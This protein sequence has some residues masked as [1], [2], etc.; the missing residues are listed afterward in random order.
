MLMVAVPDC[1]HD[2]VNHRL[3]FED[4]ND[5]T[6][7]INAIKGSWVLCKSRFCALH[8]TSDD[9]FYSHI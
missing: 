8:G 3:N 6:V 9:L 5:P 1:I 2:I 7:Y 4:P